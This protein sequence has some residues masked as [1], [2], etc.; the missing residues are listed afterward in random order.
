MIFSPDKKLLYLISTG[1]MNAGNFAQSERKLL[2]V[3]HCAVDLQI[4]LVQLR[5]KALSVRDLCGVAEKALNIT[6][7][8]TTRLMINDRADVAAAVGADGVHLTSRSLEADVVRKHFPGLL[9]GVSTH[10]E[11]E[12]NAAIDGGADL[13]VFGPV[14]ETP[15]KGPPT[16]LEELRRMCSLF[17]GFPIL[18]LGG[19][20]ESNFEQVLDAGA[21]GVASIRWLNDAERLKSIVRE[22]GYGK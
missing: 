16:G 2:D 22:F 18:G 3:I 15:G 7:N 20:D 4:P 21:A 17:P 1:E 12:V 8:S 13:A 19:V 9:I 6:R 11:V 14:F 10:S 5:E